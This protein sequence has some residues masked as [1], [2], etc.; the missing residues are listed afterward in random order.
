MSGHLR[1][2][3]SVVFWKVGEYTRRQVL[4]DELSRHDLQR[5]VPEPRTPAACLRDALGDT[6]PKKQAFK[7]FPKKQ[8]D[9]FEI[10][11]VKYHEEGQDN[12]Y[13]KVYETKIDKEERIT[14]S[15]YNWTVLDILQG[16]YRKQLGLLRTAGVGQMLVNYCNEVQG[17][18]LRPT[19]GLYWLPPDV[20][21]RMKLVGAAVERA[22]LAQGANVVYYL[23]HNMDEDAVRA[24]RD[25]ITEE[26]LA[27]SRRLYDEIT[28]GEI[29]DRALKARVNEA[30]LVREKILAYEELLGCGLAHL[31]EA[32]GKA[33]GA[34]AAGAILE[35]AGA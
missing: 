2:G 29:G 15:P 26:V 4:L 34:V 35:G 7:I 1:I 27:A 6:F 19:G 9:A 8:K 22:A 33:E 32:V 13:V 18:C 30:Q 16:N 12:E 28:S 10:V 25:A 14:L 23:T 24:V 21:P 3:G 20:V 5:V 11:A 31:K 17:T